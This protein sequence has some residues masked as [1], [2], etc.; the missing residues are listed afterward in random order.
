MYTAQEHGTKQVFCPFTC[1]AV[2]VLTLEVSLRRP[3][4]GLL[5]SICV[6]WGLCV[7]VTV[8]GYTCWAALSQYSVDIKRNKQVE[9][10]RLLSSSVI[11]P[12]QPLKCRHIIWLPAHSDTHTNA[13][14]CPHILSW[15]SE[16]GHRLPLLSQCL[17]PASAHGHDVLAMR[18]LGPG[19]TARSPLF[20]VVS[21]VGHFTNILQK[22]LSVTVGSYPVKPRAAASHDPRLS[23]VR[24]TYS[25]P[26]D[27]LL[28]H[29]EV[30]W[31]VCLLWVR[32]EYDHIKLLKRLL[33][34][35]LSVFGLCSLAFCEHL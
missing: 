15:P 32:H 14:A 33:I 34:M 35:L 26:W 28:E 27:D 6:C 18:V 25:E 10:S 24:L 12:T 19:Y 13:Y 16:K 22:N 29:L 2:K 9:L 8:A 4:L 1:V 5:S 21:V 20:A 23:L 7:H 11:K 30:F 17:F 3:R 31:S